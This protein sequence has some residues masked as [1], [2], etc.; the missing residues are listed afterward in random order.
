M[1]TKDSSVTMGESSYNTAHM[2]AAFLLAKEAL[3]A[4]ELFILILGLSLY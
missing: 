1:T 3:A 2:D 4:G